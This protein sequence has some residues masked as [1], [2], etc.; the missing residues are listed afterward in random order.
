MK[1]GAGRNPLARFRKNRFTKPALIPENA[2][3]NI[4]RRYGKIKWRNLRGERRRE[5]PPR[6]RISR[7][8]PSP[9]SHL[10][11]A[12]IDEAFLKKLG[13][14]FH[15]HVRNLTAKFVHSSQSGVKMNAGIRLC[16]KTAFPHAT[17][18]SVFLRY[19]R[20]GKAIL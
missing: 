6:N 7:E 14:T 18:H 1:N 15:L 5:F 8:T 16:L 9:F 20:H 10:Y 12:K 4:M 19:Q 3:P 2:G 13:G 11:N 17:H